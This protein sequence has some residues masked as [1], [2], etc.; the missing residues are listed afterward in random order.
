[1]PQGG[2]LTIETRDFELDPGFA[3]RHVGVRPGSYVALAVT[4]TGVGMDAT[5]RDHL[6]EP[7]FT[8]KPLGK[9]TGLGLATVY[10]IVRQSDGHIA[11][12][13]EPG[14]GATFR[15]YL[16]RVEAAVEIHEEYPAPERLQGSETVLLVEDEDQVRSL[17]RDVL[18]RQGYTVLEARHPGEAL[19]LAG[20]HQGPIHL[21]VTDVILPQMDGRELADRLAAARPELKVIYVSGYV[22][23]ASAHPGGGQPGRGFLGKPFSPGALARKVRE[24]LDA[25]S[26]PIT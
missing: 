8:T 21:L 25:V 18:Q 7:F 3:R 13:S 14:Q 26:S 1:M 4:D 19:L 2:Q 22:S 6:F 16:P 11:V 10:G 15:I 5:V 12:E 9:G 24:V 20:R 23:G 17:T